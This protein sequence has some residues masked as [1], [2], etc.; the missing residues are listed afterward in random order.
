LFSQPLKLLDFLLQV[1]LELFSLV[2]TVGVGHFYHDLF[3]YFN[4]FV[5]LKAVAALK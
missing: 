5:N 2:L 4:T 3:K 1:V